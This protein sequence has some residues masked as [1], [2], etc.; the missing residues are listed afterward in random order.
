MTREVILVLGLGTHLTLVGCDGTDRPI[1]EE[2]VDY[3][4]LSMFDNGVSFAGDVMPIFQESCNFGLC[5]SSGADEPQGNL[6]LGPPPAQDA[7]A[8]ELAD[9]VAAL[10]NVDAEFA[11]MK[12]VLPSD[13]AASFLL[14]TMEYDDLS[15]CEQ[16]TCASQ[17]CGRRMPFGDPPL[18]EDELRI[19]RTWIRDGAKDD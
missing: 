16:V 9:V 19:V 14:V 6:A 13:P 2:C 15:A 4:N 18:D 11:S 17:G 7:T 1:V 5:H 8:Q 10:V 12:L 3:S